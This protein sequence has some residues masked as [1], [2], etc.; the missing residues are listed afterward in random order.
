MIQCSHKMDRK[1]VSD[2]LL[3]PVCLCICQ[4]NPILPEFTD[5]FLQ[6]V[7]T[8]R[9]IKAGV[10][11]MVVMSMLSDY[12]SMYNN[13]IEFLPISSISFWLAAV[14]EICIYFFLE[15]QISPV[16]NYH[17][18]VPNFIMMARWR[19]L[20]WANSNFSR[21]FQALYRQNFTLQI[22]TASS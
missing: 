16:E 12:R 14:P 18:I 21:F 8:Q 3:V 10:A 11:P 9:K 5:F 7:P 6:P 19:L 13:H 15:H 2:K 4:M 20:R 1:F 22:S 17:I